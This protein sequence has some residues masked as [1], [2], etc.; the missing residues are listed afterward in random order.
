MCPDHQSGSH[1]EVSLPGVMPRVLLV[2]EA[3]ALPDGQGASQTLRALFGNYPGA[4]RIVTLASASGERDGLDRV[5]VPDRIIPA[6]INGLGPRVAKLRERLDLEVI[7]RLRSVRRV[8]A[9]FR[10]DVVIVCPLGPWGIAVG[11][12]VV[13]FT[14]APLIT[15]FMDDWPGTVEPI[16]SVARILRQADGWLVISERLR[17]VFVARYRA[18][19][20]PTLVVHNPARAGATR[21]AVRAA[22][23]S[24]PFRV[25]YAGSIWDMH[26]DALIATATAIA[27]L[28]EQGVAAELVV[29]THPS[30]WK[31]HESVWRDLGVE[32]GGLIAHSLLEARLRDADLLLV[33]ASFLPK[34]APM[35]HSS[36]QTKLTDYMVAGTPIFGVG[37]P[38]S[39]SLDFIRQWG[40]GLT[41]TSADPTQIAATLRNWMEN[42]P[43]RD[44]FAD[45][46]ARVLTAQFDPDIVCPRLWQFVAEIAVRRSTPGIGGGVA[47]A[48]PNAVA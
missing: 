30:F 24:S 11:A 6:R 27:D 39:A 23:P 16:P 26:L 42:P 19:A 8:A 21:T 47:T 17:D 1:P 4:L 9:G 34:H 18:S 37:P 38:G 22:T 48:P 45:R 14:G 5:T 32:N 7:S 41:C 10:P 20:P 35:S 29:H 15:Y 33:V 36:V 44:T 31:A 2:S 25:V 43:D 40:V 3:P 12:A 28:R 46:A 13:R